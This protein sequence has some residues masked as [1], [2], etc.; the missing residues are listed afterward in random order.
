MRGAKANS[1]EAVAVLERRMRATGTELMR[2][3]PDGVEWDE[4]PAEEMGRWHRLMAVGYR[5]LM[6]RDELVKGG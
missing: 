5:R 4:V 3:W 1:P 2:I 6:A